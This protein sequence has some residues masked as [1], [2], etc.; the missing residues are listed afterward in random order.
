V[1]TDKS[2]GKEDFRG[3]GFAEVNECLHLGPE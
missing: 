3:W 2:G 1:A